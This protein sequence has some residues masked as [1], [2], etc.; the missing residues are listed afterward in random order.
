LLELLMGNERR[1]VARA[2]IIE[3]VW[4]LH[5]D[6]M[7]NV[8]DASYNYLRRKLGYSNDSRGGLADGRKREGGLS[9]CCP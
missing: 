1:P 6:T 2:A 5:V 9:A 4:K 3:N 7:T 8:V